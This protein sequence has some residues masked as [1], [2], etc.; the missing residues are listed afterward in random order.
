MAEFNNFLSSLNTSAIV[1][2][3][4]NP[5]NF[6]CSVNFA[7]LTLDMIYYYKDN[8]RFMIFVCPSPVCTHLNVTNHM[9]LHFFARDGTQK[10]KL[11]NDLTPTQYLEKANELVDPSLRN[12]YVE[13]RKKVENECKA[14]SPEE[15]EDQSEP[16]FGIL[17]PSQIPK[18]EQE[19]NAVLKSTC[20][21]LFD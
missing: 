18:M 3:V 7:L 10:G 21:H 19:M 5:S 12:S 11:G 4:T 1:I 16:L 9:E 14:L 6:S 17:Y 15:S 13:I 20:P 8:I 2:T